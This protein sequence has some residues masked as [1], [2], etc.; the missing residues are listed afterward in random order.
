MNQVLSGTPAAPYRFLQ[1]CRGLTLQAHAS[2]RQDTRAA[3]WT[4]LR[5]VYLGRP[6]L[7]RRLRQRRDCDPEGTDCRHRATRAQSVTRPSVLRDSAQREPRGEASRPDKRVLGALMLRGHDP[8][9][10][11]TAALRPHL[12]TGQ[13]PPLPVSAVADG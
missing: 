1:S 7:N 5:P 2:Y 12:I 4:P 8:L 13:L 10:T 11:V 9:A 3:V 6:S